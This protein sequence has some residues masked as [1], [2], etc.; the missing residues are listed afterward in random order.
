MSNRSRAV[1]IAILISVLAAW[2][3]AAQSRQDN[4]AA[5]TQTAR[6]EKERVL[7][8]LVDAYDAAQINGLVF[9][10]G[11]SDV[12]ERNLFGL[13]VFAYQPGGA[14]D[15]SPRWFDLGAHAPDGSYACVSWHPQFSPKTKITL[16]WSRIGNQTIAAQLTATGNVRVAIEAYR[17]WS[18]EQNSAAW[19]SYAAQTD[20]RTILGE[21]I[22]NRKTKPPLRNFLLRTENGAVAENRPYETASKLSYFFWNSMPDDALLQAAACLV[23]KANAGVPT[24]KHPNF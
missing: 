5:A 3:R 16:R 10:T 11:L 1:F 21:Q 2:P 8:V 20:R 23:A 4:S 17:P 22:H 19:A 6:P 7:P 18:N 9:I 14:V 12:P 24:E 15:E 13:R